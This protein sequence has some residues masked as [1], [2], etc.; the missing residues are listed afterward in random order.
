[1]A[2]LPFLPLDVTALFADTT[3]MTAEQFGAYVRLLCAMWL[4]G[5]QLVDNDGELARI[6][7]ISGF[8]WR[9]NREVILRPMTT[10]DGIIT[11]KRLT[12]TW[13]NIQNIRGKRVQAG[14]HRWRKFQ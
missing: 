9:K 14:Q 12:D 11:Q 1:M 2:Q 13:L 10:I 4:H 8:K 7:G 3:H 6:A 5:G